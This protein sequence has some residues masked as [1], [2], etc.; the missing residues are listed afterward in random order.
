MFSWR[1]TKGMKTKF[2]GNG[3]NAN[4][5]FNS[6]I[7]CTVYYYFPSWLKPSSCSP[8]LFFLNQ[9]YIFKKDGTD[10]KFRKRNEST[11]SPSR[12][13]WT[14]GKQLWKHLIVLWG[15]LHYMAGSGNVWCCLEAW[16][17]VLERHIY[18]HPNTPAL[19]NELIMLC[20]VTETPFSELKCLWH[21]LLTY[22]FS[23]HEEHTLP[24]DYREQL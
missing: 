13:I 6:T 23:K 15:S 18:T 5:P 20:P 22:L 11:L 4:H 12:S 7:S 16:V 2:E 21:K 3:Q 1:N 14:Y 9:N 24:S 10:G 19:G 8:M 17:C